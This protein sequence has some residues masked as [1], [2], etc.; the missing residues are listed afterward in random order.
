MVWS[1]TP[2]ILESIDVRF[3]C[4]KDNKTS[5]NIKIFSNELRYLYK[6]DEN[7]VN[8]YKWFHAETRI[9]KE[10]LKVADNAIAT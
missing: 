3:Y 4:C 8:N 7:I 5:I 2:N 6:M 9:L 10:A 1:E